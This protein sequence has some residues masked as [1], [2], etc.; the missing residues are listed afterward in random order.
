MISLV[1]PL[2]L[3]S[4]FFLLGFHPFYNIAFIFQL[5]FYLSG[6]IGYLLDL[7]GKK[8]RLL[9]LPL[10]YCVVN[11]ASVAA[12]FRTIMGKKAVTWETVRQ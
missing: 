9:A 7:K 5:V 8:A 1:L 3:I 6:L 11:L 4:N 2:L 10:Y 12:F